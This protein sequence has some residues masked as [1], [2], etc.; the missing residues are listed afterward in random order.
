MDAVTYPDSEV[1]AEPSHW[2]RR[3]VDI[4]KEREL[5]ETFQVAA[6]PTAVLLDHDGLVLDRVIGFVEPIGFRQRL[7]RARGKR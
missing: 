3:R 6:V 5:A 7:S 1:E 4:S 2:L